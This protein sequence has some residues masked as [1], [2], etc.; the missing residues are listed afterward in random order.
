MRKYETLSLTV[1]SAL[2]IPINIQ[3]KEQIKLLISKQILAPGDYLPTVSTLADQLSINRNTINWVYSQLKEDGLLIMHKGRRTQVA[4][5]ESVE[6]L[7]SKKELDEIVEFS[8]IKAIEKG[9][10]FDEYLASIIMH[11]YLFLEHAEAKK[12][13]FIECMEHDHLFYYTQIK[14]HTGAHIKKAFLEDIKKGQEIENFDEIDS[15]ITTLNHTNEVRNLFKNSS[16]PIFTIGATISTLDLMNLAQL[17]SGTKVAFICLGVKGGQWMANRAAEAGI[18]HI[19]SM[20]GGIK[21][22]SSLQKIIDTA[23]SIYASEAVYYD[24]LKLSPEKTNLLP[25]K[26]EGT[27][28]QILADLK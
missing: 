17:K 21:E 24:L 13:L 6:S 18:N 11:H 19:I 8:L 25:F 28:E 15:I 5:N 20:A 27:S 1:N 7:I 14:K 23:D 4:N 12:F 2:P 22:N 3:L 26:L 16:K 9:F 10:N